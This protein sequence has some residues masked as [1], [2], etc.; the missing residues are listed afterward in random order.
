METHSMRRAKPFDPQKYRDNPTMISEYLNQSLATDDLSSVVAALAAI[1]KAQ[2]VLAISE[3]AAIRRETFYRALWKN[4]DPK[5]GTI[6]KIF[7]SLGVSLAVEP[8]SQGM[9]R[10]API[11]K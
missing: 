11:N 9:H 7:S 4:G 6:L 8:R 2:N 10:K 1:V 3:D 5:L